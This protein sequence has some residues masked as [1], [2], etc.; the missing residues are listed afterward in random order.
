M[1]EDVA[2]D[3]PLPQWLTDAFALAHPS[4][5]DPDRWREAKELEARLLTSGREYLGDGRSASA[6]HL[7]VL[8][9]LS[10]LPDVLIY[11]HPPRKVDLVPLV[12][13]D[14]DSWSVRSGT[15]TQDRLLRVT[16]KLTYVTR[17]SYADSV[18]EFIRP[19]GPILRT[20]LDKNIDDELAAL[21]GWTQ[22]DSELSVQRRSGRDGRYASASLCCEATVEMDR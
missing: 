1:S 8:Q 22:L 17:W 10:R 14:V 21:A 4:A 3:Q 11:D 16:L 6:V 13:V 20:L 5:L 7:A 18:W 9:R 19:D 12:I 15:F 2:T